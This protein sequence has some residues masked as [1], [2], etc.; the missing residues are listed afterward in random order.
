MREVFSLPDVGE[1]LTEA[2]IVAWHGWA[3]PIGWPKLNGL[4]GGRHMV[5]DTVLDGVDLA[6]LSVRGASLRGDGHRPAGVSRTIELAR[7]LSFRLAGHD[8]DRSAIC[9]WA[10]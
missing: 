4:P 7:Q 3:V 10:T 2:D 6:R 9:F 8:H 5:P 1:G